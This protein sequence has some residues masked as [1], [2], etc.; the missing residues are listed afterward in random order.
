MKFLKDNY[1]LL[2]YHT[3]KANMVIDS[4]SRK[5]IQISTWFGN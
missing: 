3:R 4:L 1:F 2:T 5:N